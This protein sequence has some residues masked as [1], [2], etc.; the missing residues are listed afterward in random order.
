MSIVYEAERQAI[1]G[2]FRPV[3]VRLR[4]GLPSGEERRVECGRQNQNKLYGFVVS[5]RM[6]FWVDLSGNQREKQQVDGRNPLIYRVSSIPT[7]ARWILSIHCMGLRFPEDALCGELNRNPNSKGD[8][9]FT[10]TVPRLEA[11]IETCLDFVG[12]SC[13]TIELVSF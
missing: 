12:V 7:G 1:R 9:P 8:H 4:K 10:Q 13:C 5:L 11:G 2:H 3:H 6:S